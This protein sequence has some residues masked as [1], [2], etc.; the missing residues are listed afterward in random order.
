MNKLYKR[1]DVVDGR[2]CVGWYGFDEWSLRCWFGDGHT[3]QCRCAL[4][5]FDTLEHL[6][7]ELRS[8]IRAVCVWRRIPR[9]P[10]L[11]KSGE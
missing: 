7:Q 9:R 11:H 10:M 8:E 4:A 3:A 2:E 5:P 6:R 1:G